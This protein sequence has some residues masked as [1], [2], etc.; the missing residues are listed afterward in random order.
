MGTKLKPLNL[1]KNDV[2]YNAGDHADEGLVACYQNLV[3]F[4][5]HGSIQ[6]VDKT[7]RMSKCYATGSYFGEI[8]ALD[9]SQRKFPPKTPE[10]LW[11]Y[12]SCNRKLP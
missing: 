7:G 2:L 3:Y 4:L 1:A 9:S 10:P 12:K 8:E 11:N 6:L 5:K